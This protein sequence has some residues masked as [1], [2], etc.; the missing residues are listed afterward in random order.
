M[1]QSSMLWAGRPDLGNPGDAGGYSDLQFAEFF[2]AILHHRDGVTSGL[3][4]SQTTPASK[5]VQVA[6]GTA[7][8]RGRFYRST[9]AENLTIADN[10]SGNPRLDRIILRASYPDQTIRL[11]VLQGTPGASPVPPTLTQNEGT[12]WEECL[13]VV[14]VAN[15]FATIVDANIA[16]WRKMLDGYMVGELKTFPAA[17]SAVPPGWL[18]R[19]GRAI[20][21]TQYAELY[22]LIGTTYGVGDGSTTFNLPDDRGRVEVGMDNMGTPAGSAN[23]VTG[24]WADTLGGTGGEENHALVSAENGPHTHTYNTY[25]NANASAGTTPFNILYNTQT[26]NTGSSGSGTPHNTMQPSR[27]YLMLIKA[28]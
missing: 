8:V 23:V 7:F 19:D 13:A 22:A 3:A 11:A 12:I 5:A 28:L 10:T 1:A 15:G 17:L 18:P 21:R 14:S 26:L 25:V 9:A 4:V 2:K 20:S 27:A 24:A 6:A 16:D